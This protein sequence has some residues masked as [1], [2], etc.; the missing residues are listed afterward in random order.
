MKMAWRI[1]LDSSQ[2]LKES[3]FMIMIISFLW[4]CLFNKQ[5]F[6]FKSYNDLKVLNIYCD[7]IPIQFTRSISYIYNWISPITLFVNYIGHFSHTYSSV[8]CINID[9][10]FLHEPLCY[11]FA[12]SP[13]HGMYSYSIIFSQGTLRGKVLLPNISEDYSL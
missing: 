13:L 3:S 12:S 1:L 2:W 4:I 5:L 9:A 8:C 10:R 6:H 11:F 7:F